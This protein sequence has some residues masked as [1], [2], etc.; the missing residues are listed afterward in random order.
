MRTNGA[1]PTRNAGVRVIGSNIDT[2]KERLALECIRKLH[3]AT[4]A[5]QKQD[6]DIVCSEVFADITGELNASARESTGYLYTRW[7]EVLAP[8]FLTHQSHADELLEAAKKLWGQ[9][10]TAPVVALLLHQWFIIHPEAGGIDERLKHLNIL[11]SGAKQ[12]F[13]GDVETSSMAFKPLYN[14]FLEQVVLNETRMPA[15]GVGIQESMMGVAASFLPYYVDNQTMFLDTMNEFK[16]RGQDDLV[17]FCIGRI[18][19]ALAKDVRA[20]DAC[21]KYL[22]MISSISS[23]ILNDSLRTSTRIRLQG[24]IYS[25]TQPGGPRYAS[26]RVNKFAFSVLDVLFPHGKRT[27][28][29]I[30]LFFRFFFVMEWP[31]VWWDMVSEFWR[32]IQRT[33]AALACIFKRGSLSRHAR[34]Q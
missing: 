23:D 27:R 32:M 18:V 22:E 30:N 17:D 19:D 31:S 13:L 8:Y 16:L 26:R 7:Y 21:V 33:F 34:E 28:R 4:K 10:F 24:T 1:G 29:I 12:L 11:L 25:L 6:R 3:L 15:E 14:F 9:P 20:E 5:E 2:I